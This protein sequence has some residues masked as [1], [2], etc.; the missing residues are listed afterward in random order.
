MSLKYGCFLVVLPF[1]VLA[2]LNPRKLVGPAGRQER[3]L[4]PF[5]D[6]P[7]N[8]NEID[9]GNVIVV[10]L[11]WTLDTHFRESGIRICL[12]HFCTLLQYLKHPARR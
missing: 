2:A 6:D 10:D 9:A 5:I 7:Q 4:R 11:L 12:G 8:V 3:V 1:S